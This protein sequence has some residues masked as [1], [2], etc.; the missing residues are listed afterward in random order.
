MDEMEAVADL[1]RQHL[2]RYPLPRG[3]TFEYLPDVVWLEQGGFKKAIIH[4]DRWWHPR[5][6]SR[7]ALAAQIAR[8][9][10]EQSVGF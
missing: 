3:T 9:L 4:R 10:A 5:I 1:V 8:E 2:A 6:S 7:E